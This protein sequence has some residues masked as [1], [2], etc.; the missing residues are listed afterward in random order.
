MAQRRVSFYE[1][2]KAKGDERMKP[3]RWSAQFFPGIKKVN[4]EAA[5]TNKPTITAFKKK[6]TGMSEA[7]KRRLKPPELDTSHGITYRGEVNVGLAHDQGLAGRVN[8]MSVCKLRAD[9]LPSIVMLDGSETALGLAPW[10]SLGERTFIGLFTNNVVGLLRNE[11][12]PSPQ[13]V[14]K[15]LNDVLKLSERVQL[16]PLYGTSTIK[17]IT[18]EAKKGLVVGTFRVAPGGLPK[19]EQRAPTLYEV[20]K[21]AEA[22]TGLRITWRMV[23]EEDDDGNVPEKARSVLEGL[24]TALQLAPDAFESGG[25]NHE[26]GRAASESMTIVNPQLGISVDV[27]LRPSTAGRSS[28]IVTADSAR[29][30]LNKAHKE[31]GDEIKKA[32]EADFASRSVVK[33]A[34]VIEAD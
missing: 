27:E 11:G 34:D 16:R 9:D 19:V 12:G 32:L 20:I 14:T 24:A 18:E 21:D 29:K 5:K 31:L 1:I 17:T 33:D 23:A 15:Y 8:M 30:G 3:T 4:A 25:V 13:A 28:R 10:E 26:S 2:R 7:K 22:T 6:M